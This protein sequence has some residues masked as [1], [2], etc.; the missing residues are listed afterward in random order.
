MQGPISS[1]PSHS[2][3][4]PKTSARESFNLQPS[5]RSAQNPPLPN[6]LP[7]SQS[8]D[9]VTFLQ[10]THFQ[11]F[12]N[13]NQS[14]FGQ[15]ASTSGSMSVGQNSGHPFSG[16]NL[17]WQHYEYQNVDQTQP[18][19]SKIYPRQS[20]GSSQHA[21]L[22]PTNNVYGSQHGW[23]IS[24]DNQSTPQDT[25]PIAG[26]SESSYWAA[27][28]PQVSPQTSVDTTARTYQA[29]SY[30][31]KMDEDD[32]DDP[33]DVSSD[34]E[35]AD[36]D[37]STSGR[38]R[39]LQRRIAA[40]NLQAVVTLQAHQD[41]QD[42]RVRTYHSVIENF[43]SNMLATYEPSFKDSPLNDPLACRIFTHFINVVAPGISM[44]ERHP[45]NASLFLQEQTPPKS[46][47]HLW[48]CK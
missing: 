6:I 11:G 30:T 5:S 32:E 43:G 14:T 4:L 37:D 31:D 26:E 24:S 42:T 22:L 18:S 10:P 27:S 36:A 7:R 38:A 16:Q 46:Q 34:D 48:A 19:S 17:P 25:P 23:Y 45:A 35:M 2:G 1:I 29:P 44:Y 41:R 20:P 39:D 13:N 21:R 28:R 47:Q 9:A 8:R 40:S 33:Y 3:T 15:Q 12:V